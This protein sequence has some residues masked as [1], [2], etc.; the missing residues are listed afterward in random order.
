MTL[1]NGLIS[2][3]WLVCH[4]FGLEAPVSLS[5]STRVCRRNK[6]PDVR[7]VHS[8]RGIRFILDDLKHRILSQLDPVH[9]LPTDVRC[10]YG[11]RRRD[12]GEKPRV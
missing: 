12:S 4:D 11:A 5:V 9:L 6:N 8:V 3:Q 10:R 7:D 2:P 1:G